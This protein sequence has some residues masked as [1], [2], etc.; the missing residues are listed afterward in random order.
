MG[1][2]NKT[3]GLSNLHITAGT[4]VYVFVLEDVRDDN[5]CY[6]T[7]LFKPLLLPFESEYNDYGGGENSKGFAFDMIM[8]RIQSDLVEMPLGENQYHDIEV[9][10]ENFGEELF[11]DAVHEDRLFVKD[12]YS[13]TPRKLQF[14]MFRKDVVDS[15]LE[16]RVIEQYVGD[17]KG[18]GGYGNNYTY[19]KFADVVSDLHLL[20]QELAEKMKELPEDSYQRAMLG[21]DGIRGIF[22]YNHPNKAARW[23]QHDDSYRY[24]RIVDIK[25]AI[26]IAFEGGT[27]DAL[28]KL[29]QLLTEHLKGKFI[30]EFMHCV[31]KTW[32]PGGHEGSQSQESDDHRLLCKTIVQVLDVEDAYYNEMNGEDNEE[33]E[34]TPE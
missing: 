14:T 23:L 15:I 11:F 32:I 34:S 29:E 10:K 26:R 20:I 7:S 3:C 21:F 28:E 17:G 5:Y 6:T 30:D 27:P 22:G 31:R 25:L 16:N 33:V 24:S 18:T 19:Y 12:Q 13:T 4:P 8:K 9:T 2:W 1:C